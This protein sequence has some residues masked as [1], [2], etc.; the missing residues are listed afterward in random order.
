MAAFAWQLEHA[1]TGPD[2]Y[3]W[4]GG[5]APYYGPGWTRQRRAARRRDKYTCQ[6]CG[7]HEDELGEQLNVHHIK[8]LREFNGDFD[9]ANKLSNLICY[10][11][12]CHSIVE[13]C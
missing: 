1:P 3:N 10:C 9:A 2:S 13:W 11:R 4:R 12:T 5:Y 6:R 7:I 8:A